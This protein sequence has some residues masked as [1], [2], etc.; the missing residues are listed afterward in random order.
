MTKRPPLGA[1]APGFHGKESVKP[2][3]GRIAAASPQRGKKMHRI[4]LVVIVCGWAGSA[5]AATGDDLM[6]VEHIFSDMAG[7]QGLP[8]AYLGYLADDAVDFGAG[9][10]APLYGR[11]AYEA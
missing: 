8:A 1:D 5:T 10:M 3:R 6:T 9:N 2:D 7:S 11:A 4:L